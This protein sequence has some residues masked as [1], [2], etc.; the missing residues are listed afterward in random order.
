MVTRRP[1]LLLTTVLFVVGVLARAAFD[2]WHPPFDAG[3]YDPAEVRTLGPDAWLAWHAVVG[4]PSAVLAFAGLGLLV[5]AACAQ[6]GAVLA[7]A[8]AVLAALG[9]V[10]FCAAVTAEG[11]AWWYATAD[12]VVDPAVGGAMMAAFA[13]HPGPVDAPA[14]L[15]SLAVSLGVVL[16][17]AALWRAGAAPRSLLLLTLLVALAS[18]APLP[19]WALAVRTAAE[20]AALLATG[21]CTV[22]TALRPAGA[23]DGAGSRVRGTVPTGT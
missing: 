20:A 10:A 2:T 21:G 9:S 14:G 15:G 8:G 16:L 23:T 22:R 3:I 1:A 5:V 18:A 12:G 17:L 11:V 4:G 7:A 13:A 6:R 19:G